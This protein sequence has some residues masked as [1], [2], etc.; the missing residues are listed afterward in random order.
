MSHSSPLQL[1]MDRCFGANEVT[2]ET[3]ANGKLTTLQRAKELLFSGGAII[4]LAGL[5]AL[6]GWFL[7]SAPTSLGVRAVI[8]IIVLVGL[9]LFW[10]SLNW[11]RDALAGQVTVVVGEPD[12]RADVRFRGPSYYYARVGPTE[13]RLPYSAWRVLCENKRHRWR[14]C[15]LPRMRRAVSISI[16]S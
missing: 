11:L 2:R 16:L 13:L 6:F 14:F 1:P 10:K 8:G 4:G 7:M 12:L 9:V 5:I 15:Y 3:N